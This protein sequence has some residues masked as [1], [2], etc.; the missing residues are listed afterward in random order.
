MWP[1]VWPG[2]KTIA[3]AAVSEH[4][5]RA[6][7]AGE[8]V[9]VV[10]VEVDQAVVEAVVEL[11][12]DVAVALAAARAA[13]SHSAVDTRKVASGKSEIALA[14]S[15]WR[16]VMITTFT[17]EGSMP[18]L[19]QLR[20]GRLLGPHVDVPVE[21]LPERPRFD[22]GLDRHGPVEAGVDQDRSGRRVLHEEALDRRLQPLVLRHPEAERLA[23]G[24]AAL[25]A[26]EPCRRALD[27]G[28]E[29]R[30]QRAR[31]APSRPPWSGSSAGRGSA[32]VAI[33]REP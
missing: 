13:A 23:P 2:V 31:F 3:H 15:G 4:V 6:C 24:H 14:W 28:R 27:R 22:L 26:Q 16:W 20:S 32:A 29:E 25:L 11:A 21:E 30:V 9:G 18:A 7:E 19:A 8:R 1:S 17:L 10:R 12:L 33:G 5:E